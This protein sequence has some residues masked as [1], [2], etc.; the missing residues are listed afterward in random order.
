MKKYIIGI[1]GGNTKTDYLLFDNE[2]NFIGGKRSGT[3]SHESPK[4]GGFDQAF[5][6]MKENLNEL[7]FSNNLK[8]EDIDCLVGGLAGIDSPYQ[9]DEL[10]KRLSTL[11]IKKIII[12]NDGTIGIKACATH[13]SGVC[14]INGTGTVNIGIDDEG[15]FLQI[16]GIGFVASDDGGG[17]YLARC[18]VRACYDETWRMGKKTKITKDV[19]NMYGITD[20]KDLSAS[21]IYKPVDSTYLVKSLFKNANEFDE[22]SIDI[23]STV[24][25]T[26]GTSIASLITS[27]KWN[28]PIDVI[29]A[30]SIWAKATNPVMLDKF[31]QTVLDLSKKE[32]NFI[33]LTLPPACGAILWGLEEVNKELPCKELK[34]IVLKNVEL[35]QQSIE[36][37]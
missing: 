35:Y 26:L 19:F 25:K 21:I 4:I 20:K 22:V 10:Y 13:G 24:G 9:H 15:N 30:G 31:K 17:S 1:D 33:V 14:S 36:T 23:L 7:L 34:E 3:C 6:V 12:S 28:K 8:F 11:P 5:Y 2:G 18:A 29:L 27:L 16:G 37:E 32:C